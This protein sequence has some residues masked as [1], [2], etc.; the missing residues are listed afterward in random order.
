MLIGYLVMQRDS[1][2]VEDLPINRLDEAQLGKSDLGFPSFVGFEGLRLSNL[3]ER[4]MISIELLQCLKGLERKLGNK[5]LGDV[6][7]LG[8]IRTQDF[9]TS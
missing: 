6:L 8:G 3:T 2:I 7:H 9:S 5:Q 1:V 4:G